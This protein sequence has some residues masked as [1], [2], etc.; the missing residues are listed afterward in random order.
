MFKRVLFYGSFL[1]KDGLRS[2]SFSKALF[3]LF[4]LSLSLFINITFIIKPSSLKKSDFLYKKKSGQVLSR[5]DSFIERGLD[6]RVI[7]LKRNGKIYLEFLSKQDDGSFRPI[8]LVELKGNKEAYFNYWGEPISLSILDYDGDG[9]L[10]VG[11]PSFDSFFVPH[12]NLVVYNFEKQKFELKNTFK[13]NPQVIS[14]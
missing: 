14:R 12:F 5:V 13:S 10:D 2:L 8:N 1:L 9:Q 4:I 6:M 7:K 3:L 11:A